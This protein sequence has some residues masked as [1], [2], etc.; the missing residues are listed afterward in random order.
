VKERQPKTHRWS[1][2]RSDGAP[3]N[4]LAISRWTDGRI[5]VISALEM[6]ESPVD[7]TPVPQWH[8][9]I[10]SAGRRPKP[11][12]LRRA[13]H[14]FGM[15]GTEEDNHH[16]GIA[17]HFWLPVDPAHR[18]SCQCKVDEDVIV[19]PGDYAWTNPKL[20]EGECRGCEYQRLAGKPC[21]IHAQA[22]AP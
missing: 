8:V 10:S 7:G 18:T 17:R 2:L 13:L 12:E 5:V 9:S 14:A 4:A 1:K 15:V 6:A 3:A 19:E 11:H 20:G 16:P 21:P 22:G